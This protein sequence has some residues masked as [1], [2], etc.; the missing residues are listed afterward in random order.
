[1]GCNR[2]KRNSVPKGVGPED[3]LP[4]PPGNSGLES[5]GYPLRWPTHK[6][7]K[8]LEIEAVAGR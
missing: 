1:M 4:G 3:K 8:N 5:R 6:T 7:M 2:E